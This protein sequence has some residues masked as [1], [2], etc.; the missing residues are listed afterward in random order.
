MSLWADPSRRPAQAAILG[1]NAG[2]GGAAAGAR[3]TDT[4]LIVSDDNTST[5][6]GT[7]SDKTGD[8]LSKSSR[9][10][11]GAVKK[12]IEKTSEFLHPGQKN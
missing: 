11:W 12:S 10:V 8:A 9:N 4:A 5:A 7:A 3:A 2:I 6:L 1:L